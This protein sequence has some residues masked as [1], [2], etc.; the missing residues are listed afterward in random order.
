MDKYAIVLL[1]VLLCI[2]L[3]MYTQMDGDSSKKQSFKQ[4]IQNTF[5]QFSVIERNGTMM[6]CEIDHRNE[7]DELVFIRIDSNQQKNIRFSGRILIA[8]Y[9]KQPSVREMKKDFVQHLKL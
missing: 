9:P 7:L 6:I 3:I 5:P 2:A 1:V 4:I 8:T